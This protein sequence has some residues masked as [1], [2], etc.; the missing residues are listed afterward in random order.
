MIDQALKIKPLL[1]NSK[2]NLKTLTGN[3]PTGKYLLNWQ[4]Y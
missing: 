1:A 3:W 2:S 4:I